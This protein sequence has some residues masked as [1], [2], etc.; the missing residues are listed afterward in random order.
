MSLPRR[1]HRQQAAQQASGKSPSC[2]A[3]RFL[4]QTTGSSSAR[5]ISRSSANSSSSSTPSLPEWHP[6]HSLDFPMT[7]PPPPTRTM[8]D[9]G[10]TTSDWPL[11]P[12]ASPP[13]RKT[14]TRN[15]TWVIRDA[16]DTAGAPVRP[17]LAAFPKSL[18]AELEEYDRRARQAEPIH[19]FSDN[20]HAQY[21]CR[22]CIVPLASTLLSGGRNEC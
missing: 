21:V 16:D 13:D 2:Q 20:R 5:P 18:H 7:S 3:M 9:V 22:E 19:Y 11:S 4:T 10:P 8:T 1:R 15:Q 6:S 12:T 14:A 17:N